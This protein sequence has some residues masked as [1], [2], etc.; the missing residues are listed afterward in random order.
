MMDEVEGGDFVRFDDLPGWIPVGDSLPEPW[1]DVI[2]VTDSNDEDRKPFI[3]WRDID[4]APAP[5]KWESWQTCELR[6][7]KVTHWM[8]LPEMP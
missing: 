6:D 3:A 4:R 7:C 2:V 5:W 1:A 8:N